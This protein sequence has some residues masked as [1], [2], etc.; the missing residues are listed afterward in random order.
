MN[1][2]KAKRRFLIMIS[3]EASMFTVHG[4]CVEER[5]FR[6]PGYVRD[7]LRDYMFS[8]PKPLKSYALNT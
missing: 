4:F 5:G 2:C 6:S 1:I 7:L 3:V 8:P